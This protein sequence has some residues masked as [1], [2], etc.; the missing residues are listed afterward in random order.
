[1]NR[2]GVR[3]LLQFV[4]KRA[5]FSVAVLFGV[6]V[7]TFVI[8]RVIVPD[9]ARAWAG[10]RATKSTVEALTTEFHLNDP[11]YVQFFYYLNDLLHGNWGISPTSGQPVLGSILTYLPATVELTASALLIIVFLGIPLGV[12]SATHRNK[13]ADHAARL[14]ALS[15]FASPPFLVA[16]IL[17]LI[18]VYF[19]KLLPSGGRISVFVQPPTTVTGLLTVD[20]LL[21]GNLPAFVSA[22]Q[23]LILPAF[24]LAFLTLGLMSRLV[25]TSML[26]SLSSD[27]VRTA[28]SK[29]LKGRTVTYKHALR[30]ALIQP[31]TALSVYVAWLLGGSIVIELIFSWPGIGR[32]SATAALNFDIPAIM[33]TTIV[34]AIG[35]ILANFVADVCYAVLDPRVKLQ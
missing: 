26:E 10:S 31:I 23:H 20:S 7:I 9:P 18:F 27:Y 19:L 24:S 1:L 14:M 22:V 35:V 25:R 2:Y 3:K 30:N 32:Y 13:A 16:L 4:A 5:L 21:A 6:I 8:S 11:I 29:G 15:G 28:K 12:V 17:Q 33:G 34:F